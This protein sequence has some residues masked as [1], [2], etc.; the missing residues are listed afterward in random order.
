MRAFLF[1]LLFTTINFSFNTGSNPFE[2]VG[3]I[4]SKEG[5]ILPNIYV[6][7]WKDGEVINQTKTDNFGNYTLPLSKIGEFTVMA[8]NKNQ[9]FHPTVIKEYSFHTLTRFTKNFEL[10]IDKQVLQHQTAR[11]RESYNH[12]IR[13]PKNMDYKRAF[14][15][16]FPK[17]GYET[18]LF[19][20]KDIPHKNLKKEAKT[21]M[22][23]IFNRRVVGWASY[24]NKFIAYGQKTN[25]NAAGKHTKKFYN[26]AAVL[27]KEHPA[28]LF[29]ELATSSTKQVSKF[30]VWLFSGGEFGKKKHDGTFDF[31]S[32][33][34]QREYAIMLDA[35]D[36]HL[37]GE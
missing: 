8:G 18:E 16:K 14:F 19:F 22:Y 26:E 13:N 2:L 10:D 30:F 34:Y 23:I 4:K 27:I 1:L 7:I 25:M 33:K 17:Y 15:K 20:N 35:F 24:M 21:Y 11:L 37:N 12:M 5:I 36:I 3:Q 28:E 6:Q 31:L 29:K 32:G 9:Y